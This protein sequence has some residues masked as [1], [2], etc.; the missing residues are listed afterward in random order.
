MQ[1]VDSQRA[2]RI[3]LPVRSQRH[4]HIHFS[5]I[6]SYIYMTHGYFFHQGYIVQV[7][8]QSKQQVT[9][10]PNRVGK[11]VLFFF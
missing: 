3:I 11:K 10:S 2:V 1:E 4:T 5:G 9:M 8:M 6:R 7:N